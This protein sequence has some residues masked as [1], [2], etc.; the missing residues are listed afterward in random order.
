MRGGQRGASRRPSPIKMNVK[1]DARA[2]LT[3]ATVLGIFSSIPKKSHPLRGQRNRRRRCKGDRRLACASRFRGRL[4]L[5]CLPRARVI[6]SITHTRRASCVWYRAG[7]RIFL[8]GE[9]LNFETAFW[10]KNLSGRQIPECQHRS[11]NRYC[12]QYVDQSAALA[13]P[14]FL[15][16]FG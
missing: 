5:A 2:G 6:I 7:N 15:R 16:F 4:R 14:P 11:Q 12:N 13:V 10:F 1:Y 9:S 8:L 3:P